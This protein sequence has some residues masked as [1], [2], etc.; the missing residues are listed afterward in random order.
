MDQQQKTQL[1]TEVQHHLDGVRSRIAEDVSQMRLLIAGDEDA[2]KAA[3]GEV[4]SEDTKMIQAALIYHSMKQA[5]ELQKLY[6]SP[7]FLRCDVQF[8][9]DPAPHTFYIAKFPFSSEQIVSWTTPVAAI[10]YE[11]P[12]DISYT[13]PEEGVRQGVLLRKDQYMVVDGKLIFFASA[14]TDMPREMVYQ[15]YL[16]GRKNGFVLPEIVALMEKAQDQVIRA[17]HRGPFVIS[18]PAG[19][20]KTTLALHRVAYLTQ[21]PDTVKLYPSRTIIVFVQDTGTRAYFSHLLPELGIHN[22]RIT[23]FSEWAFERLKLEQYTYQTRIGE[24]EVERDQYEY[25]KL[26]ALRASTVERYQSRQEFSSLE[27]IYIPFFTPRQRALF[28]GQRKRQQL[29]RFDLTLLLQA[30][31]QTYGFTSSEQL[32]T[33]QKNGIMRRHT[34]VSPLEYSLMVIDEFQNYLPEQLHILHGCVQQKHRSVLYVGDMAQRTQFGTIRDW[35]E[36]NEVIHPERSV[37][38]HKVYRNTREIVQY[39]QGLGYAVELPEGLR[40]G[41]E[42]VEKIIYSAEEECAYIKEI[43]QKDPEKSVGILAK[44]TTYLDVFRGEFKENSI[45]H[46]MTMREAQGVEFDVVCL[47]GITESSFALSEEERK[48]PEYVAEKEKINRDLLYVALTR[49][50]SELHVL[51]KEKLLHRG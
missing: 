16:S 15:E 18:G 40:H 44:D 21:S 20:G 50:I 22:V 13:T 39:I 2:M 47:V 1:T 28:A 49:A 37:K 38:L 3:M 31:Q 30:F 6:P 46:C 5:E 34:K 19:S 10:R 32:S 7:Y 8:E 9:D 27:K 36:I 25:Q 11:E 48:D 14:T 42:V 51:G 43:I 26:Q 29:D 35:Q 17:D 41:E 45:V 12:G 24:D 33:R 4:E 23:T